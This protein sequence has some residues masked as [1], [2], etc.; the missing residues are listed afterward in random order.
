MESSSTW[1]EDSDEESNQSFEGRFKYLEGKIQT[2]G[3]INLSKEGSSTWK[4]D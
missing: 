4:E 3:Q 2:R 1:K